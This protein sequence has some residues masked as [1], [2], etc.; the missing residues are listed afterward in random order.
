LH[1]PYSLGQSTQ[2]VSG[3]RTLLDEAYTLDDAPDYEI[4][5]F[6]ISDSPLNVK[7]ILNSAE[8]LARNPETAV[9]QSA[10]LFKNYEVHTITLR[11]E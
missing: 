1:Y 9:D 11:K 10:S 6:I 3:K 5:F 7:E 8:S 2:L 4:F